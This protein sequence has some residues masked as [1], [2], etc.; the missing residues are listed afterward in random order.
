LRLSGKLTDYFEVAAK[1]RV[2]FVDMMK[3]DLDVVTTPLRLLI[4]LKS[5]SIVEQAPEKTG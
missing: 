4:T 1:I 3:S 5:R 2:M